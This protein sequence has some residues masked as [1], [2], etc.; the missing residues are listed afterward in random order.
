[1]QGEL[2]DDDDEW[3]DHPSEDD[4]VTDFFHLRAPQPISQ[5]PQQQ[6]G[7]QEQDAA[8]R[9][10]FA[11]VKEVR[12]KNR[13][14]DR[15]ADSKKERAQKESKT[16]SAKTNAPTRLAG[17]DSVNEARDLRRRSRHAQ[18]N[19]T[20][21]D[22]RDKPLVLRMCDALDSFL[23]LRGQWEGKDSAEK[24]AMMRERDGVVRGTIQQL[25]L[26]EGTCVG[27]VSY[28]QKNGKYHH[29]Y[30]MIEDGSPNEPMVTDFNSLNQSLGPLLRRD[31]LWMAVYLYPKE[32]TW[33]RQRVFPWEL[34]EVTREKVEKHRRGGRATAPT[35]AP[36]ESQ[37]NIPVL[38]AG[39]E[40]DKARVERLK[41]N[42][43]DHRMPRDDFDAYSSSRNEGIAKAFSS[44]SGLKEGMTFD[45]FWVLGKSREIKRS[46]LRIT[47]PK[48]AVIDSGDEEGETVDVPN[49]EVRYLYA[50]LEALERPKRA[51]KSRGAV[52]SRMRGRKSPSQAPG[53]ARRSPST[54]REH[55]P[56]PRPPKN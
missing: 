8:G 3:E 29:E 14:D 51:S 20:R 18:L 4:V 43:P 41:R 23:T 36:A 1:M 39:D 22:R 54:A 31:R 30:R 40:A 10:R 11:V 25:G 5:P 55:S 38:L 24:E 52:Y 15:Y 27:C 28:C 35:E 32:S 17:V 16:K 50:E 37:E 56:L 46:L 42:D 7:T 48:E 6:S 12:R 26:S 19:A 45:V 33:L 49:H 21:N 47:G 53:A 13:T 2:D 44:W 34:E 9:K